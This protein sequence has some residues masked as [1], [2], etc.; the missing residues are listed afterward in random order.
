MDINLIK[1]RSYYY[2]FFAIP[3]FFYENDAKFALWKEQLNFLKSSPIGQNDKENFEILQNFD[4]TSFKNEQNDILFDFSFVNVPTTASF[5]DEGRD[6]GRMKIL[7]TNTLKKSK[8]RRNSELCKDSEDFIGF[9]FYMQSTLLKYEAENENGNIFLSTELFAN[10]I[11]EFCDHFI[12]LLAEHKSAKFFKA[13]AGIMESFFALERS[14][15]ALAKPQKERNIAKESINAKLYR[16][17]FKNAKHNF[18]IFN[19]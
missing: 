15:L 16:G 9:I 7:I 19:D 5:Y 17:K 3:F 13:L 8:F 14:L 4:F 6:E 12:E 2:E 18:K 10:V 11:N 1:A